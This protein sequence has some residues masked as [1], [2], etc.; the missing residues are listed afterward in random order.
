MSRPGRRW[1]RLTAEYATGHG[2][3]ISGSA[4]FSVFPDKWEI[5]RVKK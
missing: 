4:V 2:T 3:A 1:R 5:G